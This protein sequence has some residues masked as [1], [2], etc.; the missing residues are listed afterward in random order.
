MTARARV[1]VC[2]LVALAGA[3]FEAPPEP[4]ARPENPFAVLKALKDKPKP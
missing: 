2:L 1:L 3:R 4:E